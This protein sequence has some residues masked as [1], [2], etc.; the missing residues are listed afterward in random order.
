MRAITPKF[1]T[2]APHSHL[3]PCNTNESHGTGERKWLNLGPSGLDMNGCVLSYFEGTANI[4]SYT[5]CTCHGYQFNC[6]AFPS[7]PPS[8]NPPQLSAPIKLSIR[9]DSFQ[10]LIVWSR[11]YKLFICLITYLL[12]PCCSVDVFLQW[13][14][15]RGEIRTTNSSVY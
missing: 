13:T 12:D 8:G 9:L 4:H 6:T 10:T 7:I 3:R 15:L 1:N 11:G 2:P 14:P 5:S